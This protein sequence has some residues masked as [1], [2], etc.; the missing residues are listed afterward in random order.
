MGK[1]STEVFIFSEMSTLGNGN[2]SVKKKKK[3][4]KV[5]HFQHSIWSVKLFLFI[6]I[7]VQLSIS[8]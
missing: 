7:S 3:H 2:I 6:I 4:L 1:G 5:F 8:V